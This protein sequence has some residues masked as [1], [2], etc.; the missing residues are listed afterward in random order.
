MTTWIGI[1][2]VLIGVALVFASRRSISGFRGNYAERTQG[3]VTQ[4]YVETRRQPAEGDG[5]LLGW[6]GW[7]VS[8]AGVVIAALSYIGG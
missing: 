7:L 4:T 1:G 8:F 2:M 6:L 3:D 5:K